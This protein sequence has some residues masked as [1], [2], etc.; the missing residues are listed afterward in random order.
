MCPTVHAKPDTPAL[1]SQQGVAASF[2][3]FYTGP[4]LRRASP[5]RPNR[6]SRNILSG[7]PRSGARFF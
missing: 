4:R 2:E 5:E 3:V 7:H 1:V 6:S